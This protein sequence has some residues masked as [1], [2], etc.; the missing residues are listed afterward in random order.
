MDLFSGTSIKRWAKGLAK[1]VRFS[2]EVSLY[3]GSFHIFHNC[4]VKKIVP[5]IEDF[6][7]TAYFARFSPLSATNIARNIFVIMTPEAVNL[8]Q[9]TWLHHIKKNQNPGVFI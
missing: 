4:W 8:I 1:F 5:Y 6:G 3:Q 7:I 2:D 9:A